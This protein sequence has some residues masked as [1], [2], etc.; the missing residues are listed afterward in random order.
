MR[1]ASLV[2]A[3]LLLTAVALLAQQ[4]NPQPAKFDP[5]KNAEDWVVAKW[6]E[7]MSKVDSLVADCQLKSIDQVFKVEEK[8][9]GKA[10]YLRTKVANMASLELDKVDKNGKPVVPEV[11]KK[12]IVTGNFLYQF[13]PETKTIFVHKMPKQDGGQLSNNNLL[14][15]I[16]GMKAEDAKQRYGLKY[17]GADANYYYL[18]IEP[19]TAADKQDFK[20]ARLTFIKT[21][22][23]VREVWFQEANGNQVFW[24][25]P[26]AAT[27]VN[28]LTAT[29]F[30]Q[31]KTPPG[32]QMK[33]APDL[34]EQPKV[35]HNK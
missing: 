8:F 26:S 1:F 25:F 11:F 6:E 16:F 31:P 9:V 19:K 15:L 23:M 3:G 4:G 13:V 17:A 30:G 22:F 14:S 12:Y 27:N 20:A 34:T 18:T 29:D 5:T 33:M 32:W 10:K 24:D 28:N 2:L 7:A 21:N 35:I